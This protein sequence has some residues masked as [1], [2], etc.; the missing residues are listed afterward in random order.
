VARQALQPHCSC[1]IIEEPEGGLNVSGPTRQ[2]RRV[3]VKVKTERAVHVNGTRRR[4]GSTTDVV[5][6]SLATGHVLNMWVSLPT[7]GRETRM[8]KIVQ[9][10]SL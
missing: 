4:Q 10:P 7:V 1:Q 3:P 9:R 5:C 2:G 8:C 6:H